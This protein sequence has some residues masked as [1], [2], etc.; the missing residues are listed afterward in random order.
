MKNCYVKGGMAKKGEGMAK[1]G[2][3]KG[4]MADSLSAPRS[5]GSQ[6]KTL[7]VPT[8]RSVLGDTVQVRGVGAARSRTAKIY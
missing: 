8:R 3:A 1:K 4:G 5:G 7:S 6:G 2:Y